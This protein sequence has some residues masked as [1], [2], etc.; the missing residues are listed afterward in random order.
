MPWV[1]VANVEVDRPDI[2]VYETYHNYNFQVLTS[3]L[4]LA[5]QSL[6]SNKYSCKIDFGATHCS[7]FGKLVPNTHS[8]LAKLY[9]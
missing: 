9:F 8:P 4:T 5:L 6:F 1:Q 2:K 3:H 7:E